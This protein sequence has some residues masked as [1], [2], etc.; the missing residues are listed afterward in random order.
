[1]FSETTISQSKVWNHPIETTIEIS[2]I[3]VPDMYTYAYIHIHIYIYI[4]ILFLGSGRFGQAFNTFG[5]DD[6]A[7]IIFHLNDYLI[8]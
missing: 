1:M 8:V 4:Y 6:L 7:M 2:L 3:R 5:H